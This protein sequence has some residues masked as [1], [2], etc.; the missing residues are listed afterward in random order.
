MLS[1]Y[2][3]LYYKNIFKFII[4]YNKF[5]KER[6]FLIITIILKSLSKIFVKKIIIIFYFIYINSYYN[7]IQVININL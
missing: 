5:Y 4:I 3:T 7:T 1:R 2:I 6:I